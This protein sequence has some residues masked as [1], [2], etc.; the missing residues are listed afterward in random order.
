MPEPSGRDAWPCSRS[1]GPDLFE[2][3][4]RLAGEIGG[5]LNAVR[6]AGEGRYACLLD[7]KAVHFESTAPDEQT[8]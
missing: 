4:E 6:S 8:L 7:A 5:L 1:A 2:S 3:R